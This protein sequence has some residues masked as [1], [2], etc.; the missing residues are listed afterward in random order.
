MWLDVSATLIL[1]SS[2]SFFFFLGHPIAREPPSHEETWSFP[3]GKDGWLTH[4]VFTVRCGKGKDCCQDIHHKIMGL[5]VLITNY[6][7]LATWSHVY[8]IC[9][10]L[11]VETNGL[12]SGYQWT[13][14]QLFFSNNEQFGLI[15]N[16]WFQTP[17]KHF[18][19]YIS[20]KLSGT[21][22]RCELEVALR[23]LLDT[24][25][26]CWTYTGNTG[27]SLDGYM[28]VSSL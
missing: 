28:R 1:F 18:K 19:V 25:Q 5:N 17:I 22:V 16:V 6:V 11:V 27:G 26:T 24:V 23:V 9:N 3:C 8:S 4:I 12:Q 7:H 10:M 13:I 21:S 14:R 2:L 20:T 15:R